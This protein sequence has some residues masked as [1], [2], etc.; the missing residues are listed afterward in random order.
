M[1]AVGAAA[2]LGLCIHLFSFGN[3]QDQEYIEPPAPRPAPDAELPTDTLLQKIKA[4]IVKL[5][6]KRRDKKRAKEAKEESEDD[7][8]RESW[9]GKYSF[10]LAALGYTGTNSCR[11]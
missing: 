8:D 1:R 4:V 2:Q 5:Y 11:K 7:D 6:R 3:D 10:F 9:G